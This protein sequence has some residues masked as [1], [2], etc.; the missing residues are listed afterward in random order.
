M[1]IRDCLESSFTNMDQFLTF[2]S[3]RSH[4]TFEDLATAFSFS[5]SRSK[6]K[7]VRFV[8]EIS[9]PATGTNYRR[10]NTLSRNGRITPISSTR[11]PSN[12]LPSSIF[13]TSLMRKDP[14][15]TLTSSFSPTRR[16]QYQKQ[17]RPY[18]ILIRKRVNLRSPVQKDSKVIDWNDFRIEGCGKCKHL[19]GISTL[20]SK[21]VNNL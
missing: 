1:N 19:R 18:E 20:N 12:T 10:S 16:T 17:L 5:V 7:E 15:Q 13:G 9:R 8:S 2:D 3:P 14:T 11:I 21:N 4:L 6:S